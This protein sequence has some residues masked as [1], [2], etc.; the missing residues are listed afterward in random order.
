[1]A[2]KKTFKK[3]E[4]VVQE[5]IVAKPKVVSTSSFILDWKFLEKNIWILIGLLTIIGFGLRVYRLDFLTLWVDEYIHVM[6]ARDFLLYGT[7]LL[8]G[9]NNGVILTFFIVPLFKLF[10]I[11]EFW[12]RFPSVVFGSLSIPLI[13]YLGRM[14]F[15]TPVGLIAAFISTFS[16]Y[17]IFWSRMARNYASFEFAYLLLIIVFWKLL[18]SKQANFSGN[19]FFEKLKNNNCDHPA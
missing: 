15:N 17:S 8:E 16:W 14:L 9:E 10:A 13:F 3:P 18:E 7:G 1:M 2:R 19:N 6:R 11:N 12:A 4:K 5:E